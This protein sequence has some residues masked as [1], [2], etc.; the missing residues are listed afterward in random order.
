MTIYPLLDLSSPIHSSSGVGR[1]RYQAFSQA[2]TPISQTLESPVENGD[3]QHQ[4]KKS[5]AGCINVEMAPC[6]MTFFCNSAAFASVYPFL[7]LFYVSSGLS[8]SQAGFQVI[9]FFLIRNQSNWLALRKLASFFTGTWKC[10]D[11]SGKRSW[12]NYSKSRKSF[13]LR[14]KLILSFRPVNPRGAICPPP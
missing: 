3:D 5:Q 11:F 9:H 7:N 10:S 12:L 2:D 4:Q 13:A 6:K 8:T 1:H 14:A